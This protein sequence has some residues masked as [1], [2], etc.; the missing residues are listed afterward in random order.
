VS[1]IVFFVAQL[2]AASTQSGADSIYA[3]AALREM[4]AVAAASN[5]EPPPEFRSYEA[6]V[7]T[8]L[9]LVIRDTIGR[10]R[11]AQVEQLAATA[12]WQRMGVYDLH[13]VGYRSQSVGVPYSALSIVRG[14]TV[15][16]LYGDRLRLGA[17]FGRSRS[18][19]ARNQIV[20][21]HPFASDRDAYYTF[22]GGDTITVLRAGGRSIP[23][24]RIRVTPRSSNGRQVGLFSGEVDLD[25]SRHQIVRMRGQFLTFGERQRGRG[26]AGRLPGIVAVAYGEFVSAEF[27]GRYWLPAVQ[28][29]EFQASIAVLGQTRSVFRLVS[30]FSDFEIDTGVAIATVTGQ[31]RM[32]VTYAPEDSVS[33]FRDWRQEIG[34]ATA[35][36]ASDDFDDIGPDVWRTGGS[37]RL[38]LVPIRTSEMLRFNRVEGFYTG[39]SA[40]VQFRDRAPGVSVGAFGGWAWTEQTLRG[41]VRASLKRGSWTVATR[42]ERSLDRTNDFGL[43]LDDGGGIG[44]LAGSIDDNDYVARTGAIVSATRVFGGVDAG[45]ATVQLGFRQ[46]RAERARLRRGILGGSTTF[47]PNRGSANGGY[48]LGVADLELHPNVTGDFVQPGVG[49]RIHYEGAT[50]QLDWQ[51]IEVG[52]SARRYWGPLSV[53]A[54]ADGGLVLG[55]TPP[56]QT[57][58]ELGGVETLPGYDYKEFAGNRAALFR[59]FASVRFPIW[60]TPIRIFRGLYVPGLGPGIGVGAQGGWTEI[61]SDG[62]RRAV[63]ALGAGWSEKLVSRAT[64]GVR[65]TVGAGL[66]FF[67]DIVHVGFARPVDHA[68]PWRFVIGFGP[69]F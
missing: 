65:A 45:L 35:S 36:V 44:A 16:S 17:N 53:A 52:L 10:E 61:S 34:V 8:E 14:W 41:G 19:E 63:D 4:V 29:T 47:R 9:S 56:P 33:R 7:E 68:A 51:R 62:A 12:R 46:D 42:A 23:I 6:R 1:L 40:T 22:A 15:P 24:A 60:R 32:I 5:R 66:T 48:A 55:A 26:L 38:D 25:A 2:A 69:G 18:S 27:Q 37:P 21:V 11:A 67:S 3:S 50:G 28:R 64:N 30:R 49:A 57:L 58:L 13:I 54:H 39:L 31:P 20:A 59:T 43:P